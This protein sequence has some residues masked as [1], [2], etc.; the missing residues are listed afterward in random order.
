MFKRT[1][2]IND[3]FLIVVNLIPL[4]GVWFEDGM[5]IL[6]NIFL[7][8]GAGKVFISIFVIVKIFFEVY[9]NLDRY[10]AIAEKRQAMKEERKK[11]K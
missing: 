8:F 6:G 9:V 10:M 2:T 7:S 1:L 3:F 5:V 11:E 4:Y